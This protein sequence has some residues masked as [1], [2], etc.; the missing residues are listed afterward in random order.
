MALVRVEL[1]G[2]AAQRTARSPDYLQA[3]SNV[4]PLKL[5]ARSVMG[6]LVSGAAQHRR[7][8]ALRGAEVVRG[9]SLPGALT[10]TPWFVAVAVVVGSITMTCACHQSRHNS[11]EPSRC[12]MLATL[13]SPSQGR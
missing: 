9:N 3:D 7:H 6:W 1:C 12:S 8:N 11:F 4:T 10:P 5:T 13:E 2:E